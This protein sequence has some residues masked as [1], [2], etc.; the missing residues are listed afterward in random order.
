[1]H[2]SSQRVSGFGVFDRL[3]ALTLSNEAVSGS[4]ALRLA[5]SFH[6]APAQGLLQA[7]SASLH[8]GYSVGMMNSFHFIGFGWRCW[9]TG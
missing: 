4:L 6:G 1:V 7:L 9:R 3:A 5:G 2:I 8:A